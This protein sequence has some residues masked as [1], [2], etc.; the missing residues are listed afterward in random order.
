VDP[1]LGGL[2]ER[3]LACTL[4]D[5]MSSQNG[6]NR[7][8]SDSLLAQVAAAERF[9]RAIVVAFGLCE[10]S[11]VPLSDAQKIA[12]IEAALLEFDGFEAQIRSLASV[13]ELL[14]ALASSES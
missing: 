9:A 7:K 2:P 12:V 14:R 1:S 3:G 6:T 10:E 4:E 5:D 11:T 8:N 13:G